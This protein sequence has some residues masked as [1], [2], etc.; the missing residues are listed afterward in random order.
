M[1]AER[2]KLTPP[3]LAR[4]LGVSPDK[5]RAWIQAGELRAVNVAT[6]RSGTPRWLIDERDLEAFERLRTVP[7]KPT[8]RRRQR[9]MQH[10]I[11]FF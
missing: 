1:A 11:K 2:R 8:T 7:P 10:I 9:S 3:M 6:N 5:I 4:R